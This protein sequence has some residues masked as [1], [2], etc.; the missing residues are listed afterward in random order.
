MHGQGKKNRPPIK[1]T[2]E[3]GAKQIGI[4][5]A[6]YLDMLDF[7]NHPLTATR[8][9]LTQMEKECGCGSMNQNRKHAYVH[10]KYVQVCLLQSSICIFHY[11]SQIAISNPVISSA[12]V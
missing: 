5:I 9:I 2:V 3:H 12:M 1:K 7:T 8:N 4:R 10:P 6:M 11:I